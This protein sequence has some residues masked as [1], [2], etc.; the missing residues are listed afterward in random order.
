MRRHAFPLRR[1]PLFSYITSLFR[2]FSQYWHGVFA[3]Y[4]RPNTPQTTLAQKVRLADGKIELEQHD[5]IVH[6]P[7]ADLTAL[8]I[9]TNDLGPFLEDVFWVLDVEGGSVYRVPIGMDPDGVFMDVTSQLEG[10]SF[11]AV[12]AAQTSTDNAIFPVWRR[13]T[14]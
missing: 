12:I 5:G 13:D 14:E 10:A 6:I 7:I 2:R 3:I 8:T 4:S 9:E 11:E 1:S